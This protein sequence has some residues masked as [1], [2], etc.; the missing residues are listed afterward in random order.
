M[1][2]K[3]PPPVLSLI[4]MAIM[5]CLP[6]ILTLPKATWL[7]VMLVGLSSF[8][9]NPMY[10]SLAIFL[11]AFAIYLENATA[12]LVIPLFIWSINYLQIQPEEQMLEQKFGEEYLV[13]KKSVRRWV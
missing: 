13:Y 12:L 7:V 11:V 5:Y 9:R 4:C 10:L 2:T 1:K 6:T 3:I 8:S